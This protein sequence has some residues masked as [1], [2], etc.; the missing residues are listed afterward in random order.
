MAVKR[1]D[2][3]KVD[4]EGKLEDGVIFDSSTH[5]DHSHPIEFTVG[6][7]EVVKGFD[8]A[9][10]GMSVGEEKE[11]KLRPEEAYGKRRNELKQKV[12]R[13]SIKTEHELKKG[14]MIVMQTSRGDR[15]P[16]KI[17][18]AD[19]KDITIDLNHPLAGQTLTFKIKIISIEKE[20][21][22]GG[23]NGKIIQ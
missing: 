2:K 14:M 13:E 18:E 23:E 17:L 5:G 11:F 6:V 22:K 1:G 19:E 10:I 9:V 21:E 15:V 12:P 20:M 7:G 8:E 16:V 3:I 4:Y